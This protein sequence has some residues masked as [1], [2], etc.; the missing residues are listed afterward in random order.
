MQRSNTVLG[1]IL[2]TSVATRLSSTTLIEW[3]REE[4]EKEIE[5]L[6]ALSHQNHWFGVISDQQ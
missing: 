1:L 4:T 2:S 5:L 6:K 3:L